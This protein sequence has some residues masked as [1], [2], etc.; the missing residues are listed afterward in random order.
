MSTNFPGSL[1]NNTT[2]PNPGS[3]NYT[4]A[5]SHA[6]QHSN[7]NDAIKAVETK[8]GTGASTP[9]NN[10]VF[11]GNGT[12]SSE[13]A[14]VVLT[15]DVTG[16]L[17]VAN[18]GTGITS[19]GTGVATFLGTPSSA[20]LLAAVT[21]ETGTGALVFGTSPTLATPTI[22]TAINDTNGNELIKFTSV[23]SAV[24]DITVANAASGN[25]PSIAVTGG[26][27]NISLP[28][29]AKGTGRVILDGAGAA[30]SGYVATSQ[31]ST[32]T[33]YTDLATAGPAA[34]VT[35]G[36]SGMALVFLS[37]E[38]RGSTFASGYSTYYAFAVSGASTVAA[39]DSMSI[40]WQPAVNAGL[41]QCGN[42][43]LV[44]GLTPGS[45]TFTAK[46]K[47]DGAYTGTWVERRI[48][49]LPL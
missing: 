45:N 27:A 20:N 49:V 31:T 4:D 35:I 9:V 14:Q 39:V 10:R 11:R 18:G 19:L 40:R 34:T 16:T 2:L 1:D 38:L 33:S 47:V 30:S 3:G 23:A 37:A 36:R 46:Y 25:N 26:G 28:I 43:F 12:G 13:W 5:P 8:I 21:D 22:T 6:S 15:T 29:D 44:T 32:S 7:E 24:N 17:P 42:N 48:A 41:N